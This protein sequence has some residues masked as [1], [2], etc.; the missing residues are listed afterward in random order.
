MRKVT[1][2]MSEEEARAFVEALLPDPTLREQ[3][4]GVV[5]DSAEQ[6]HAAGPSSWNL[7]ARERP[8]LQL[9]VGNW[10]ALLCWRDAGSDND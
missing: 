4:L 9:N 5:A 6:A 3:V 10:A 8:H 1:D 2:R 7:A